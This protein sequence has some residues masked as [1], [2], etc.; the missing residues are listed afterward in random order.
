MRRRLVPFDL[1][2]LFRFF[3]LFFFFS[4]S[5]RKWLFVCCVAK[6][7]VDLTRHI[8]DHSQANSN[9]AGEQ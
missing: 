8:P 4:L 2:S 5:Q 7:L 3:F 1:F 6:A 9:P